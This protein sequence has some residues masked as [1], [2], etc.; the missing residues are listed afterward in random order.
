MSLFVR[1]ATLQYYA[2][3]IE[4]RDRLG[5]EK[6]TNVVQPI[7]DRW[8]AVAREPLKKWRTSE[9]VTVPTV[10]SALRPGN[11][12]DRWFIDGWLERCV[13]ASMA[14]SLLSDEKARNLIRERERRI[15]PAKSRSGMRST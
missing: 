2:L 7:F 5:I 9:F 3:L 13:A 1:G 14:E 11:R 15:K 6:A 8:W 10:A 12:G 4:E